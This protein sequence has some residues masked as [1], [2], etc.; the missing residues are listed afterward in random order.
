MGIGIVQEKVMNAVSVGQAATVYSNSVL[1]RLSKGFSAARI[2]TTAGSIT[3][4]IQTSINNVD[5]YD[6]VDNQGTALGVIC[7]ALTVNSTTKGTYIQFPT[8][9]SEYIRIKVIENNSAPTVVT[10][11]LLFA[12]SV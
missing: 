12:E 1:S 4:S 5:F 3:C 11:D 9:L 8:V 7:S 2:L 6:P 10:I